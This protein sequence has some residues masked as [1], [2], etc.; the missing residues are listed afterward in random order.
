MA[1]GVLDCKWRGRSLACTTATGSLCLLR[2]RSQ[3]QSQSQTQTQTRSQS[4]TPKAVKAGVACSNSSSSSISSGGRGEEEEEEELEMVACTEAGGQLFL[5]LDWD[6]KSFTDDTMHAVNTWQGEA[7]IAVSEAQGDLSIFRV[8]QRAGLELEQRWAAHSLC[9]MPS[10]AWITSFCPAQPS[11]L[12]SGADDA[13]LKGWDLRCPISGT[14]Q[15]ASGSSSSSSGAGA[16]AGAAGGSSSRSVQF[17]IKGKHDAGV[18]CIAWSPLEPATYFLSGS[19]DQQVF[20]R[21]F[22]LYPSFSLPLHPSSSI[23]HLAFRFTLHPLSF[24]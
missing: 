1:S 9:G 8:N 20:V 6:N 21:P 23:L 11:L 2:L 16:G 13:C 19:Y 4:Q 22:I 10:E 12:L 17:N 24:I 15:G 18:T 14:D 7:R 5:S 3:S